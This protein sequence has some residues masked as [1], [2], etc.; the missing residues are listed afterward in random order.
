MVV[1]HDTHQQA[2]VARVL[3]QLL[4]EDMIRRGVRNDYYKDMQ[5][6]TNS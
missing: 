2:A 5:A 3:Q 1:T 4:A 6:R